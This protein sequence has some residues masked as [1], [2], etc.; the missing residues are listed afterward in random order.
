M[1]AGGSAPEFFTSMFGVFIAQDNVGIGTIVGSA[2]FNILCVLA[3]C[4]LFS[5]EVLQLTWWPLFRDMSFYIFALALL[6]LFFADEKIAWHEALSMLIVYILY[7][8][9][10]KY[11]EKLEN[12]VKSRLF[13]LPQITEGD[14][15][16]SPAPPVRF[17]TRSD[18]IRSTASYNSGPRK[19][20]PSSQFIHGGAPSVR[21]GIL[22]MAIG[23][24][25]DEDSPS[26]RSVEDKSMQCNN[27]VKVIQVKPANSNNKLTVKPTRSSVATVASSVMDKNGLTPVESVKTNGL[28]V[29]SPSRYLKRDHP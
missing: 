16:P 9:F 15:S 5:R 6:V 29:H 7:G 18:S 12:G 25:D 17:G 13:R 27:N 19:S 10:M 22:S 26:P 8:I 28:S 2:T 1:A 14:I 21:H 20:I 24:S 4:T 23:S 3:F 11:N